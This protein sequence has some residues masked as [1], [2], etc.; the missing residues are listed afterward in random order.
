MRVGESQRSATPEPIVLEKV[1]AVVALY[2]AALQ[3]RGSES[4]R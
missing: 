3:D 4:V 1:D 2:V